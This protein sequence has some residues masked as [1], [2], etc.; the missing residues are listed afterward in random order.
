ME[1]V[2]HVTDNNALNQNPSGVQKQSVLRSFDG[3]N[4]SK[5]ARFDMKKFQ[6]PILALLIIVAGIVSGYFLSGANAS[7]SGSSTQ[8]NSE[9]SENGNGGSEVD[10]SQFTETEEGVL[11]EGG[12]EGEGTHYLDRGLG[13]QKY[14]YLTSTVLNLDKYVGKKVR[15]KGNTIAGQKAGY[16]MEVGSVSEIK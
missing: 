4:K 16:L 10:E 2:V 11:M 9:E 13:E 15:I 12:I 7:N 14:V 5:K 8:P 6:T 3:D 1:K